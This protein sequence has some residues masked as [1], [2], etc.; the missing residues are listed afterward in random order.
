MKLTWYWLGT[1]EPFRS[2]TAGPVQGSCDVAVIGGGLTGCSAALALVKKGA[3]V[4]L[5]EAEAILMMLDQLGICASS[6]SA[7]TTGS[8][9]PS[10]VLTAMNVH[11]M[12]ARGSL[13]F[14]LGLYNTAEE[15]EHLQQQLPGVIAKLRAISPLNPGHRDNTGYDLAAERHQHAHTHGDASEADEETLHA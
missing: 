6:G 9:D 15:V 12:R 7:C 11:P 14:S 2:A 10:H 13:R 5:V 4:V 8:S 3:H 1:L